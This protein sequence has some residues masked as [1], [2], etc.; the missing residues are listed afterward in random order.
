L[1]SGRL[2]G[3]SIYPLKSARG[4]ALDEADV[5]PRGLR[6]DRDWMVVDHRNRFVTQRS[7]GGL[8]RLVAVPSDTGLALH[9]HG[10]DPMVVLTPV[11]GVLCDVEVWGDHVQ[12]R[13]AGDAVAEWL[14]TI[15]ARELRLVWM[16]PE[17]RRPADPD[18]AGSTDVP[19]SFADGFPLLIANQ[20]S[21]DD[22]NGR[23]PHPI[24]M[25]RFRPN[26]VIA[27]WP[28]F[29]ED[30]I[31]RIRCGEVEFEL[32]KPCTRC[33]IPSLDQQTG[34]VSTDPTPALKAYRYDSALRGVTFGVNAVIRAGWGARLQ[35]GMAVQSFG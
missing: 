3:L 7:L 18:Y 29:A 22:L 17:A 12:A 20:A 10:R 5:G 30:G 35:R 27:D 32:V 19:V 4:I 31:R 14:S 8:A 2:V 9:D 28:A 25:D 26:M 16:P 13:D 24:P 1:N 15:Y 11:E 34:E 6:G 23:L 21:L 33:T